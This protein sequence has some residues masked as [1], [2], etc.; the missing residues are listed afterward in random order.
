[1]TDICCDRSAR[2]ESLENMPM[3]RV[4]DDG[5]G[6]TCRACDA[7]LV[8]LAETQNEL[9]REILRAIRAQDEDDGCCRR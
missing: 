8:E 1:M 9:L 3:C 6:E 2:R 4:N 5:C 7:Q